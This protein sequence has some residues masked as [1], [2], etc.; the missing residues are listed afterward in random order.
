VVA[1]A[2]NPNAGKTT[3]FNALTGAHQRV[4]NWPGVTVERKVGATRFRGIDAEIVDLPGIY[5]LRAFGDD[6][7]VARDYLL[8]E[9][10]DLVLVVVDASNL[11]RNL[12]LAVQL[13][14]L[15]LPVLVV[16]N[17]VD[18]ARADGLEIDVA[19]LERVLGAGV[20]ETVGNRRHGVDALRDRIATILAA[21]PTPLPTR[22]LLPYTAALTRAIDRVAGEVAEGDASWPPERTTGLLL[23]L[24]TRDIDPAQL[25]GWPGVEAA[26]ERLATVP[27]E[28]RAATR[29]DVATHVT[30]ARYDWIAGL[31]R[32]CTRR[33][34]S[35]EQRRNLT[36][37]IDRVVTNRFLGIPLFLVA[38]WFVFQMVFT[39]GNP[40]AGLIDDGFGWV[41]GLLRDVL[42]QLGAPA[43]VPSLVADGLLGGVGSV[44]VF[45]PNI[46]ILF[47]FIALLEDSGYMA[48][49]AFVMDRVMHFFGL[50]GKSFIPMFMGFGCNIPALMATRSLGH[51]K[52]RLLT[53]LAIPFMSCSA[54][55]T[56]FVLVSGVFFPRHQ[57]LVLFLLYSLGVAVAMGMSR[58]LKNVAFKEEVAPL[59]MELPP[60]KLPRLEWI[61]SEMAYRARIFLRKAGTLI[62]AGSLL[63]WVAASIPFG[64][65]YASEH[66]LIGR[67]GQA[68]APILE[69]A[70]LGAWQLVVALLV[71]TIAKEMVV[72]TLATL[73]GVTASGLQAHLATSLSPAAAAAFMVLV[74]LYVPCLSTLAVLKRESGGWRWMFLSLALGV[75]LG[76]V[77]SVIVYQV[78]SRLG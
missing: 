37:R 22:P 53:I 8:R 1:V 29:T 39:V 55:L 4:G 15:R 43:W 23:G 19:M 58:L 3:L 46:L 59:I 13:I 73:H 72:S 64:E 67:V 20:V 68:L 28:V 49:A 75:G 61:V 48:R 38:L 11:E 32:E 35:D 60:Y 42:A 17:M 24:L 40:V 50:H 18:V 56:V 57:G 77:L 30:T 76:Y 70:G 65:P 62:L 21:G 69:P 34:M 26:N 44:V 54:R 10:A 52:D 74:L 14:E 41:G 31:V 71:G 2:G 9:R 51:R 45:L 7:R 66:T 16:L 36:E 5:S 12:Y 6:E 25:A 33:T 27:A 63:L 47:L 78:G